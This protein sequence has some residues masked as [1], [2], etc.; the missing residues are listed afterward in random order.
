MQYR[1]VTSINKKNPAV[2]GRV[3]SKIH[4]NISSADSDLLHPEIPLYINNVLRG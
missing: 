4:I 2:A 1:V 3:L